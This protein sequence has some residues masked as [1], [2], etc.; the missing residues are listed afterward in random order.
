VVEAALPIKYKG[1]ALPLTYRVDFL[2]GGNVLVEVKALRT[3]GPIELAQVINYLK[4]SGQ[5]ARADSEF[6][7]EPRV[8]AGS[9]EPHRL[10]NHPQMTQI[11]AD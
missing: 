7:E 11:S 1:Q 4:A 3:I 8:S 5:T 2:S 9:P 6:R 10:K